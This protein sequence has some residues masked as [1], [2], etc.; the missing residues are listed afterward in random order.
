MYSLQ[1]SSNFPFLEEVAHFLHGATVLFFISVL[2]CLGLS[3]G[4]CDVW[5]LQCSPGPVVPHGDAVGYC[6]CRQ[7]S[8]SFLWGVGVG[9]EV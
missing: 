9:V 1:G 7:R 3:F 8:P 2:V 4:W 6:P 5:W